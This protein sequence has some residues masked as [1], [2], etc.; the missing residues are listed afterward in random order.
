[1]VPFLSRATLQRIAS[2]PP[3]KQAGVLEEIRKVEMMMRAM[4]PAPFQMKGFKRQG[5]RGTL[6]LEARKE[7]R[8][9]GG[10]STARIDQEVTMVEE[11]GEWKVDLIK[12]IDAVLKMQ[13]GK[14]K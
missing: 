10:K 6:S 14:H 1:M 7:T 8:E 5:S 13:A 2:L 4:A 12:E 9:Q 3:D 11:A